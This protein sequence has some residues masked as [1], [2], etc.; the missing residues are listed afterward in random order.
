M[1]SL[2]NC[3]VSLFLGMF[4]DF[5]G[6]YNV[7]FFVSSG[8]V[9]AGICIT[10]VVPWLTPPTLSKF[11]YDKQVL[12]SIEDDIDK[13]HED[14]K[15]Y[16]MSYVDEQKLADL[17]SQKKGINHLFERNRSLL[18]FGS[19]SRPSSFILFN[20][21]SDEHRHDISAY[22]SRQELA[23]ISGTTTPLRG[24]PG[25]TRRR[26][27]DVE[28]HTSMYSLRQSFADVTHA[29][30]PVNIDCAEHT[31]VTLIPLETV[32][33]VNEGERKISPQE[34]QSSE[35]SEETKE[36]AREDVEKLAAQGE[37]RGSSSSFSDSDESW[38][39]SSHSTADTIDSGYVEYPHTSSCKDK[40][41]TT[42][43][44][45]DNNTRHS[46]DN[47]IDHEKSELSKSLVYS[48]SCSDV[49]ELPVLSYIV[50]NPKNAWDVTSVES[51]DKQSY[52]ESI[53]N[54]SGC[55]VYENEL[56]TYLESP[57]KDSEDSRSQVKTEKLCWSTKEEDGNLS[58]MVEI[59]NAEKKSIEGSKDED[60]FSSLAEDILELE[61]GGTEYLKSYQTNYSLKN[62]YLYGGNY[63]ETVV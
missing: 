3:C 21:V 37:E 36:Q 25:T 35:L 51:I 1:N 54:P 47:L 49:T 34:K 9:C 16:D 44:W 23:F 27:N 22:T 10:F 62:G 58:E 13:Y 33:E 7:V 14:D 32:E 57:H 29:E 45:D 26:Y 11:D 42:S 61:V 63:R 40:L 38:K 30:T 28:S 39:S 55:Y 12:L 43:V 2:I 50:T 15:R 17:L 24:T 60:M 5:L 6:N 31:A 48:Y 18:D 8:L 52:V 19:V 46:A 59:V 20:I 53:D 41:S 56:V 4:Y